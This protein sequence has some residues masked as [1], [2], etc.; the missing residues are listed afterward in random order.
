MEHL[1]TTRAAALYPNLT[2]IKTG[3]AKFVVGPMAGFQ[4][5][6]TGVLS[7]PGPG[8][9]STYLSSRVPNGA[10]PV[11]GLYGGSMGSQSLSFHFPMRP[12]E[13]FCC[14]RSKPALPVLA[15]SGRSEIL[16]PAAPFNPC[17]HRFRLV[18]VCIAFAARKQKTPS[19]PRESIPR[20]EEEEREKER[21]HL[22]FL[23]S[24]GAAQTQT[25]KGWARWI[26]K[27]PRL[28]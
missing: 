16:T 27:P 21:Q 7:G 2:M 20:V 15:R 10:S 28:L 1:H 22:A 6:R 9:F 17:L 12:F 19:L 11:W 13:A 24:R 4:K 23:D 18:G 26:T 5:K 3:K 14:T 8:F 25:E